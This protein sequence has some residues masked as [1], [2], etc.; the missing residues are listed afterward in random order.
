M[1]EDRHAKK[2]SEKKT[3]EVKLE[4]LKPADKETET[5]LDEL[6]GVS[7]GAFATWV[8]SGGGWHPD[9]DVKF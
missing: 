2:E 8:R 4:N 9:T 3:L 7:G 1:N 5:T 6:S